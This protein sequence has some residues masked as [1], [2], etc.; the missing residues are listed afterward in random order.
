MSAAS[1]KNQK[2]QID[3]TAHYYADAQAVSE[4]LLFA[5][6]KV[7][8]E[9]VLSFSAVL[10]SLSNAELRV[11]H[12]GRVVEFGSQS[13]STAVRQAAAHLRGMDILT[14]EMA[15]YHALNR[16]SSLW[17]WVFHAL[18]RKSANLTQHSPIQE[19]LSKKPAWP[20]DKPVP[21]SDNTSLLL[22]AARCGTT[23]LVA[24]LISHGAD[25]NIRNDY[26]STACHGAA[27]ASSS[28][29]GYEK[30]KLLIRAGA[31]F[32]LPDIDGDTPL[33]HAFRTNSLNCARFLLEH[34]APHDVRNADNKTPFEMARDKG[35]AEVLAL[36]DY[37]LL[38]Q[39]L[40]STAPAE[41]RRL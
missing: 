33:H 41:R 34:N 23:E 17:A 16:L 10:M 40:I 20:I 29:K 38:G 32:S 5:Y 12:L 19:V 1:S 6:D 21:A 8:H 30:L 37:C 31:S 11:E 9:E 25:V 27:L 26:L 35:F 24:H 13:K 2:W 36:R 14:Q 3:Q 22:F 4:S 15:A 39:R 28:C 18:F 7:F